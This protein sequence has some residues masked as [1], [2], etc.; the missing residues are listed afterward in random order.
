MEDTKHLIAVAAGMILLSAG[1]AWASRV[2]TEMPYYAD[3]D[4]HERHGHHEIEYDG[5]MEPDEDDYD[6]YVVYEKVDI[7]KAQTSFTDE[8]Y[9]DIAGTYKV[10]LTD[11]EFPKPMKESALNIT[12]ATDS[13]GSLFGPGS[14]SFDANPGSYYVSF[15]ALAGHG[16]GKE[17]GEYHKN[18]RGGHSDDEHPKGGKRDYD[19]EE[20]YGYER[21]YGHKYGHGAKNFGQY[22]IEIALM[23]PTAVPVPAAVWLFGSGLI[24]L[25]GVAKRKAA[26]ASDV[27][28]INTGGTDHTA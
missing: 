14:F 24:G 12:T 15:F 7:F 26:L 5:D 19:H 2:S 23:H 22:G 1:N 27:T 11:F 6:A 20:D 4:A 17:H 13:L 3:G 10:T 18:N 16:Y 9:V 25:V 28:T 21:L 8:F